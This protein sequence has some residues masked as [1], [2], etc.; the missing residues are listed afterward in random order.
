MPICKEIIEEQYQIYF[1]EITESEKE[2]VE[3]AQLTSTESERLAIKKSSERRLQWLACRVLLNEL[4]EEKIIITNDEY[5]KP[6]IDVEDLH[7]TLSHSGKYVMLGISENEIGVD[8]ELIRE[9]V[10]KIIPK[11]LSETE[12]SYLS[13]K[14]K[15]EEALIYW[16]A[17]ESLI[18]I[19]GKKDLALL[20]EINVSKFDKNKSIGTFKGQISKKPYKLVSQRLDDYI[21]VIATEQI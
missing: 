5:G 8:I 17:K 13:D 9:K 16:T 18:K 6:F 19:Y 20:T 1:W 3:L 15:I 21:F 14:N 12:I 4:F 10:L 7:I 2:L 11:F